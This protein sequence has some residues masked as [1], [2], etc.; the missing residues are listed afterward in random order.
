MVKKAKRTKRARG[1]RAKMMRMA[2]RKRR[3]KQA[4]LVARVAPRPSQQSRSLFLSS[5]FQ[6]FYS[7][8][9]FQRVAASE[10]GERGSGREEGGGERG[11][12]RRAPGDQAAEVAD[13]G[14]QE[15][16]WLPAGPRESRVAKLCTDAL[17]HR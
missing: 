15:V 6:R 16:G 4:R 17:M 2:R 9:E 12:G 14:A 8:I 1:R 10:D 11:G 5:D 7:G 3:A 13:G